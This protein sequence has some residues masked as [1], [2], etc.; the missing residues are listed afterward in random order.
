MISQVITLGLGLERGWHFRECLSYMEQFLMHP[1]KNPISAITPQKLGCIL[2]GEFQALTLE[3]KNRGSPNNVFLG[4]FSYSHRVGWQLLLHHLQ[5]S[6][7][8]PESL[9]RE[10][11]QEGRFLAVGLA[12]YPPSCGW[13]RTQNPL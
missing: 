13:R 5:D 11:A 9:R 10:A 1:K 8:S 6:E 3:K 4:F 12:G 2:V 7:P